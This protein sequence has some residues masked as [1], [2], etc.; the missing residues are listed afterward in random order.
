M[1]AGPVAFREKYGLDVVKEIGGMRA[2]W[3]ERQRKRA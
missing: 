2:M 3:Q 1:D